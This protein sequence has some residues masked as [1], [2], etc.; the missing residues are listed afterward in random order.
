MVGA[1]QPHP[2]PLKLQ[3]PFLLLTFF[4]CLAGNRFISPDVV[5]GCLVEQLLQ[6]LCLS[7]GM[8]VCV[9]GSAKATVAQLQTLHV[10]GGLFCLFC[11]PPLSL[12]KGCS[13]GTVPV[14][15]LLLFFFS[16]PYCL[17]LRL[18]FPV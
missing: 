2:L 8:P 12:D 15:K 17:F 5:A 1:P 9:S 3:E 7:F 10:V 6:F 18:D 13:D 14:L 11:F 4:M 16:P